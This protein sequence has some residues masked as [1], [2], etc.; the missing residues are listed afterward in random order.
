MQFEGFAHD[1]LPHYAAAMRRQKKTAPR[2]AGLLC[3]PAIL[4]DIYPA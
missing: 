4:L 1:S 3:E 2:G